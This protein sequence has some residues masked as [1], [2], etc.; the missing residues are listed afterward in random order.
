MR[1]TIRANPLD[2]PTASGRRDRFRG[3]GVGSGIFADGDESRG[4]ASRVAGASSQA[5][6]AGGDGRNSAG[7]PRAAQKS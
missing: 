3:I 4:G 2:T 1:M 6:T 5:A 7:R